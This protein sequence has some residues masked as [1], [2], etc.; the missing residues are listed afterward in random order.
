MKI[1]V[2][3]AL[4]RDLL[5]LY[6]DGVLSGESSAVVNEHLPACPPCA[7]E[8][9]ALRAPVPAKKKS[10]RQSLKATRRRLILGIGS[11]VLA[12]VVLL[13]STSFISSKD[14][15]VPYYDGLFELIFL[16]KATADDSMGE[17]DFIRLQLARNPRFEYYG[18]GEITAEDVVE[19]DSNRI[20]VLY[21]QEMKNPLK[22][23]ISGLRARF[24]GGR[25]PMIAS[26]GYSAIK[27]APMSEKEK[28]DFR[29]WEKSAL[30][31]DYV[32]IDESKF[33]SWA[34]DIP[35][36]HVYYYS[37]PTKN[38]VNE[39]LGWSQRNG[40]FED[41]VLIYDDVMDSAAEA[42]ER[43]RLYR[44]YD[45][46]T[47]ETKPHTFVQANEEFTTIP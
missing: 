27:T 25:N 47:D 28:A 15:P 11:A 30:G 42:G 29:A 5:P 41:S 13:V 32:E 31:E 19:V 46:G 26:Y 36:T 45:P 37:G 24:H 44:E 7:S 17:G 40:V 14:S 1:D 4:V 3:C 34:R 6:A 33:A 35:I 9:E 18:V 21:V 38:L 39:A 2:T 23:T 43:W 20:G 8:L 16:F 10:A 12:I 22:A